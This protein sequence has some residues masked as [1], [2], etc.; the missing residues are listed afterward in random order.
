QNLGSQ[1]STAAKPPA[2]ISSSTIPDANFFFILIPFLVNNI[3]SETNIVICS[4]NSVFC[5]FFCLI[6]SRYK[7]RDYACVFVERKEF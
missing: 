1:R 2:P 7:T 3:F 4:Q 5:K 6:I